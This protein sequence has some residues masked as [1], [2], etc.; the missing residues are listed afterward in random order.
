[1]AGSKYLDV[2]ASAI[3]AK[4]PKQGHKKGS[5]HLASIKKWVQDNHAEA[6]SPKKFVKIL[7]KHDDWFVLQ[8]KGRWGLVA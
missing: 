5:A 7:K 1:M 6:Y 3:K 8:D 2:L 4:S